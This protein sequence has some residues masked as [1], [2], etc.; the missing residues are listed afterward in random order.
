MS[1]P[2]RIEYPGASYHVMNRGMTNQA[3]FPSEADY[4]GYLALIEDA[5]RRWD[6]GVFSYCLMETHYHLALQT[7]LGNLHR[8]MRHIDGVYT[9]RFNRAHN[10]D[11]PLF[12][13]R[14][15]AILI[16]KDHYLAAVVRYIHLSTPWRPG[17]PMILPIIPGA[18]TT[19]IS[20]AERHHRGFQ[21][22]R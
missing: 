16:D 22:G 21:L 18:A 7:P 17:W 13:G 19:T 9:Q 6:V 2:L 3:L 4:T 5:W 14:Y 1:R 10:R 20:G 11:G 12:R 8:V 15:R